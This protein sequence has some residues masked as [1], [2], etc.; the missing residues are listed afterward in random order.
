MELDPFEI[1]SWGIKG[2]E[3]PPAWIKLNKDFSESLQFKT[4]PSKVDEGRYVVFVDF[5][6]LNEDPK[7]STFTFEL[8]VINP[9]KLDFLNKNET[10]KKEKQILIEEE[11][12]VFIKPPDNQ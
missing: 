5:Q 6:D 8:L 4:E 9:E 11:I 3:I 2:L 10:K 7:N 12:R 1:F